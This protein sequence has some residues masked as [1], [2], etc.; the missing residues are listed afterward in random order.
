MAARSALYVAAASVV[1]PVASQPVTVCHTVVCGLLI[2]EP[3]EPASEGSLT[4]PQSHIF[5]CIYAGG[6]NEDMS[7]L[8]TLCAFI[9]VSSW[10]SRPIF[11][12]IFRASCLLLDVLIYFY[13]L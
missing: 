9:G 5:F 6:S 10:E 11:R 2:L 13:E 3:T 12:H 1:P 8:S 7:Y 4:I